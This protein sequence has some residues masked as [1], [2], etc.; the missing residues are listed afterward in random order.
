M[1]SHETFSLARQWVNE[2]LLEHVECRVS[3]SHGKLPT[4]LVCIKS[5]STSSELT[6]YICHGDTLPNETPYVTLSHCWGEVEFITTTRANLNSFESS[7]PIDKLSKTFQD[8]FLATINL[9]FQYIWIDSLCIVQ[10]DL[11]D[12]KRESARMYEVYKRASCN[13]SA[14][15]FADGKQ[16]FMLTERRIDPCPLLVSLLNHSSKV[17]RS[18]PQDNG[19]KA[20]Y[21]IASESLA[22]FYRLPIFYRAWTL[23]EQLLVGSPL[24]KNLTQDL[25][26]YSHPALYTS[27]TIKFTGIANATS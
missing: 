4:R 7:L 22:R 12:W 13:V 6:A 10:D 25:S 20:Y 18:A 14:S 19:E 17:E 1:R 15:G 3:T 21:W 9:G 2:C 23:Q 8:A 27:A 16:G 11:D 24:S 5:R 26:T